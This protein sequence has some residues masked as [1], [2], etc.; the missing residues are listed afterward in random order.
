MTSLRDRLRR[1]LV[2]TRFSWAIQDH[3][4]ARRLT[5]E[6]RRELGATAAEVGLARALDDLG[7]PTALARGYLSE[8]DRPI[9]RWTTGT[10]W[11][12]VALAFA[13][14]TGL[15]YA[16]GTLDT[17][18]E[19]ADAAP[20]TAQRGVLGATFTY[21]GGPEELSMTGGLSWGWFALH[22]LVFAVPFALGA[23]IW[24]LWVR[25]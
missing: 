2:L 5:R 13:F 6:L 1:D 24:R 17:L 19:L 16:F 15:A 11:G 22:A 18:Q 4:D 25:P 21:T 23:R 14:Y 8:H 12:A 7:S 9:P 20:L 10:I 3:P